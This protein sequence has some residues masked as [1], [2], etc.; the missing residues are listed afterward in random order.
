M[1]DDLFFRPLMIAGLVILL[2]IGV[3]YRVKSWA[4]AEPLDRRQEGVFILTTLRPIAAVLWL[5]VFAFLINPGWLAWS[6]VPLPTWMRWF[7]LGLSAAAVVTF[8]WTLSNL[9]PNLTDTVVTRRVHSL[10][11]RGPY[12][13]VR[14][15]FYGCVTMLILSLALMASNWFLLVTGAAVV[16]LLVIRT[17]KEE[18]LLVARFGDSYRGYM[19]RTGRFLPKLTGM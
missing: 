7:G 2:S 14:H 19:A 12:R 4:A 16:A 1:T 5:S 9:G 3:Y 13:W 8:Y 18:E 10:V 17:R 15:P 11:M 6:S